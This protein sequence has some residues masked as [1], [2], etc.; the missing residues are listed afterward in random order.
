MYIISEESSDEDDDF[1]PKRNWKSG[2]EKAGESQQMPQIHEMKKSSEPPQN[3][4]QSTNKKGE[5]VL[6]PKA[7]KL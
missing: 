5:V 7:L 3:S 4:G 6:N 2:E 1:N